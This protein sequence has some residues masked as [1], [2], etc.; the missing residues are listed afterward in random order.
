MNFSQI[1]DQ[2]SSAFQQ[3]FEEGLE[4]GASLALYHRGEKIIS[5]YK[6]WRD[7]AKTQTWTEDTLTL[8][9]S[10]GKGVASAC[11]LHALQE[12]NISL[13]EKVATF[14]PEFAQAGK[15]KITIA[16]ILS[17]RAGLAA[18]DQKGIAL[19]DHNAV[20]EALAAQRPNWVYD[21]S[22][23]YGARTFGFLV[24]ELLRRICGGEPLAMYWRR[25]FGDPLGLD[26]WFGVSDADLLRV[27]DVLSPKQHPPLSKFMLAYGNPFS[28][29]HRTFA[30]PEGKYPPMAMNQRKIRQASIISFGAL[31]T[32]DALSRFYSLLAIKEN[33]PFFTPK[34]LSW[35]ETPLAQGMDRV[36]LT[37]TCF[38][39][40]FMMDTNNSILGSSPRAFGH[41]GAGG[42]L[43][44]ADPDH[45]FGFTYLPNA[46]QPG[47]L[48]G[49]RTQRLVN[50][51]YSQTLLDQ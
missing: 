10:A 34:T 16:Q 45:E 35:L 7:V 24:D 25:V 31:A 32:A 6:G 18:L 27:A 15:E 20:V 2:L 51:I 37:E 49:P 4:V 9:W 28:L 21:G 50:A 41:P 12:N 43:S 3:N 26:L 8:I 47:T 48:P 13:E 5:L 22:H 38:S 30:E 42:T 17:H 14:W 46:M 11:L 39:A 44:F 40:G 29:T 33:N 23:G 19:T 36:L 1:Q